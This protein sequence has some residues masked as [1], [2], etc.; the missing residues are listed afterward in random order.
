MTF[1]E[2][3]N[4]K[5]FFTSFPPGSC[6]ASENLY[7]HEEKCFIKFL[8][9]WTLLNKRARVLVKLISK[10]HAIHASSRVENEKK[11]NKKK[12]TGK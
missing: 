12:I 10:I 6:S 9:K 11:Q 3:Y 1:S 7:K 5:E 2:I 4:L 8:I